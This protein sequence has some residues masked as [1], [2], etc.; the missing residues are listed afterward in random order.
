[1]SPMYWDSTREGL[2]RPAG[3]EPATSWFVAVREAL[4]PLRTHWLALAV[5]MSVARRHSSIHPHLNGC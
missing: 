3:L 4:A 2:A 5:V 1:M